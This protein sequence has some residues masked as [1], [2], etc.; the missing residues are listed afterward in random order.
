MEL[1]IDTST[2]LAGVAI[3]TEGVVIDQRTWRADYN[4]TTQLM[5]TIERVLQ[6]NDLKV[7]DLGAIIVAIGPGSFSGLR[8][9]L[10]A[11]KGLAMSLDLPMAAV[12]TLAIE[13]HSHIGISRLICPL[14]DAGR[15]EVAASLFDT[16]DS[17]L[18][19][20]NPAVV[21]TIEHVCN[22]VSTQT[23]FCGE[24]ST[25]VQEEIFQRLGPLATFVTNRSAERSPVSLATLGWAKLSLGMGQKP[26]AIQP[27]YLRAPSISKPKSTKMFTKR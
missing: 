24:L 3:S 17:T 10:S 9:G 26:E 27:I 25:E 5:P 13:A 23:L 16:V 22:W 8:V 7:L 6:E 4:H 21:S 11:A 15:G 18:I 1:S 12:G 14:L 19:E 20:L 2:K